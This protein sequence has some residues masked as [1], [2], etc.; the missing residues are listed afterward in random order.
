MSEVNTKVNTKTRTCSKCTGVYRIFLF[1]VVIILLYWIFLYSVSS[2]TQNLLSRDFMNIKLFNFNALENC[3]SGWPISHFILFYILG[4]LFPDCTFWVIGA[5]VAWE[6]FEVL[7]SYVD[8]MNR[9]PVRG[10]ISNK[11]EYS[12]NWW[13]GSSKDILMNT[14][15]FLLGKLTVCIFK[16]NIVVPYVNDDCERENTENFCSKCR[17]GLY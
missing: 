7:L 6:V 9:Q 17:T 11:I 13:A 8:I 15:G 3:C 14:V 1:I 4:L 2:D 12:Q 10:N 5:G 16:L